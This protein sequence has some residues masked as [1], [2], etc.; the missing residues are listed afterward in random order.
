MEEGGS[1]Q[2]TSS[3]RRRKH[4]S[5]PRRVS[6]KRKQ[7]RGKRHAESRTAAIDGYHMLQVKVVKLLPDPQQAEQN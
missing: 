1:P 5:R 4:C 7:K 3:A 2:S 6:E